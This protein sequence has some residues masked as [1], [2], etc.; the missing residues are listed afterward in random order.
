MA[1]LYVY[2]NGFEVGEYI[3]RS[4]GAQ[5]FIYNDR[6]LEQAAAIP[7]SLSLPLT[8]KKHQ[9]D[10]VHNYF[11][12]LLP[13]NLEIRNRI[14]SRVGSAT[15]KPFDLLA[16]IGMD[17]VGAIQ[18]FSEHTD[19]DVKKIECTPVSDSEIAQTLKDYQTLPL[20]MSSRGEFRMSIAGAQE[21]TA[22]LWHENQWQRPASSTPTTHIFKLPIGRIHY[23]NIDLSES[24]ENEWLCIEI[25]KVF[26]LPV[27]NASIQTFD[28]VKVL[29]VE[30][31]DRKLAED[32]SWIIRQPQEDMCQVLGY[33]PALKYESDGGPG[34]S[35]IMQVLTSASNA[36]ASRKQFMKS[37]FLF[38]LLGAIDGHAKNFSIFLK[39]HGRFELTPL[40]DV[41]SAFP[42]TEK[43][44]I[45]IQDIKMAMAIHSKNRHYHPHEIVARHW[46]SQAK[47]DNFPEAEMH[48]I[49]TE[50]I[51]SLDEV[52]TR[53]ESR[54]PKD[55]PESIATPIFNGMRGARHAV[56]ITLNKT[57]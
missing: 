6:W 33:A 28:D 7:L 9:G 43:K 17:C 27:T 34:I 32:K 30:R 36:E 41:I 21:K 55:F 38:W 29:V 24:L 8:D 39:Q 49:I 46:F 23:N 45:D 3:N 51:E 56:Q 16:D 5:E 40:Y 53:V 44:Q 1:S 4:S 11:D 26:G 42:L 31:F 19:I 25:L 57:K 20:G 18:L 12:N 37:V 50:A 14:Q 15:N 48:R 22:F 10:V 52:I 47:R 54:L 2:M 13:D 35:D